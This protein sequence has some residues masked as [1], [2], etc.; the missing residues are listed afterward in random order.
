MSKRIRRVL[1]AMVGCS[2]IVAA[3]MRWTGRPDMVLRSCYFTR[4]DLT[5]PAKE[6]ST[7]G[8]VSPNFVSAVAPGG[9]Y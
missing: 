7:A 5:A 9:R 4:R 3:A 2:A 8:L 6:P 1:G